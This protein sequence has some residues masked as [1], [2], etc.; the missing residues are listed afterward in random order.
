MPEYCS[1]IASQLSAHIVRYNL[2][3]D[4]SSSKNCNLSSNVVI[5]IFNRLKIFTICQA[6][7]LLC[8]ILV[9]YIQFIQFVRIT[10]FCISKIFSLLPG[11]CSNTENPYESNIFFN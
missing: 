10:P 5:F 11:Q 7:T 6:A 9:F 4:V 1:D 2:A 8:T 3:N